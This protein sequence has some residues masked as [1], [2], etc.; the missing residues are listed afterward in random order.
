AFD[1]VDGSLMPGQFA[2][3]SM[4]RAKNEDALLISERAVGTDQDKKYVFVIGADNKAEYRAVALGDRAEGLRIVT[5]GLKPD[6]RIVVNGLQRVKP[7]AEV[8]PEVVDMR[9]AEPAELQVSEAT[10]PK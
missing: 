8:A 1:N 4:G 5:S 3:L 6:E 10:P 7:G 2:R 9:A